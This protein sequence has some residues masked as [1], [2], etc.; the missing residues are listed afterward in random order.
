MWLLLAVLTLA[1]PTL[2]TGAT[3]LRFD[4]NQYMR[5]WLGGSGTFGDAHG[6]GSPL[7]Q[8]T[9]AEDISLRFRT[10]HGRGL[11]LATSSTTTPDRVQLTL[12]GARLRLDINL[13]SGTKV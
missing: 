12:Q 2:I 4:G 8:R 13:G 11:L 6:T 7:E 3:T 9:E 1:L 5:L 10:T